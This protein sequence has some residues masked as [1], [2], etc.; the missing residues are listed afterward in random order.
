MPNSG[1]GRKSHVFS[2][3]TGED[4]SR[5]ALLFHSMLWRADHEIIECQTKPV[6]SLLGLVAIIMYCMKCNSQPRFRS[7]D[8]ST[9]VSKAVWSH[10]H[11]R[12]GASSLW[13]SA[14]VTRKLWSS[15]TIT[16]FETDHQTGQSTTFCSCTTNLIHIAILLQGNS[17][18]KLTLRVMWVTII[19]QQ[20]HGYHQTSK[21]GFQTTSF[22]LNKLGSTRHDT[23][24]VDPWQH[25]PQV[26]ITSSLFPL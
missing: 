13:I 4:S 7:R 12:Q 11:T 26:N 8:R 25:T 10:L 20:W 1:K 17:K 16:V 6:F 3:Q 14:H 24:C 5:C 2:C 23:A 18:Q 15:R 21:R 22:R 19:R 9:L